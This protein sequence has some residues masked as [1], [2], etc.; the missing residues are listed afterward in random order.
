MLDQIQDVDALKTECI[1]E[2]LKYVKFL[3]KGYQKDYSH[4]LNMM[5]FIN[6]YD[7]LDNRKLTTQYLL[8]YAQPNIYFG[9]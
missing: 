7:K 8:N 6:S 5:C 1:S 9:K 3:Q 2:F 4:I